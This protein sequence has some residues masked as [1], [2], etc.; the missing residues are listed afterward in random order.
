MKTI[1]LLGGVSWHSTLEYYRLINEITHERLGGNNSA[2]MLI[3]SFNFQEVRELHAHSEKELSK[4][5][6]LEAQ[7]LEDAGADCLLIG[8]NTLHMFYNDIQEKLHIPVIH[9]GI[10]TGKAIK[11]KKISKVGLLGTKHTMERDFYTE[12]LKE[13]GIET[14]VP[15][16]PDRKIISDIIYK[17]LVKGE[18]P[19]KS[20]KQ[21][22]EII[23]KLIKQHQIE[24]LILGCTEIP[25]LIK[26]ND[27][28]IPAFNTTE[29]HANETVNFALG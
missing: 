29:I 9:I 26:P 21:Y 11:D 13:M 22:L 18:I 16:E 7:K 15:D 1:G 20:K 27:L 10:A 25:L 19:D 17:E 3:Y 2:R 23:D 4:R 12:K 28:P 14:F 8:A 5:L 6:V 24:G